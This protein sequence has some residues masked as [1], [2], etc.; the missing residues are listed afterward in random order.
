SGGGSLAPYLDDFF[1]V[2]GIPILNGYGSTETSPVITVRRI[3]SNIRGTVGTVI[4]QTEISIRND[5]GEELPSGVVGE[6]WA[7]GPQ[8]M[9]GYYNNPEATRKVLKED[10]WFATGD[11]GRITG[12]GNL[13]ITGRAKDTI[14]LSSG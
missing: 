12:Q 3:N 4:G 1:E 6:I 14:V 13:V 7:R 11:L 5:R 9:Q 2:L 10:G 8:V